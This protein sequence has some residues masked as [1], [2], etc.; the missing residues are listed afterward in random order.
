MWDNEE[1]SDKI[2]LTSRTTEILTEKLKNVFINITYY[3]FYEIS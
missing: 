2:S 3:Y 1:K